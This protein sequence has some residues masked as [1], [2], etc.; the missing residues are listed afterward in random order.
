MTFMKA[1]AKYLLLRPKPFFAHL[2]YFNSESQFQKCC[3]IIFV[4]SIHSVHKK[5]CDL[6]FYIDYSCKLLHMISVTN[7]VILLHFQRFLEIKSRNCNT[8]WTR[9]IIPPITHWSFGFLRRPSKY[10]NF[11]ILSRLNP[12][13]LICLATLELFSQN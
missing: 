4:Y 1:L 13:Q 8:C 7:F 6:N 5:G 3:F 12:L 11:F 9:T 2:Y 10:S